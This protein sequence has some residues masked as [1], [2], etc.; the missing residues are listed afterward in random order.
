MKGKKCPLT[1]RRCPDDERCRWWDWEIRDCAVMV[2]MD[3]VLD[4]TYPLDEIPHKRIEVI[5]DDKS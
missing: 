3:G 2:I 1:K 5:E 4:L